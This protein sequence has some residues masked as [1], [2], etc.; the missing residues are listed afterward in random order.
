MV[1]PP[2]CVDELLP[3]LGGPGVDVQGNGQE[4]SPEWGEAAAR[5]VRADIASD[6]SVAAQ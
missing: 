3:A 1:C 4:A 5:G 6:E 2:A